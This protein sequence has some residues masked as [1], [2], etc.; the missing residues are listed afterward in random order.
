MVEDKRIFVNLVYEC[1][2]QH[3]RYGYIQQTNSESFSE[4]NYVSL[5]FILLKCWLQYFVYTGK[6]INFR[7]DGDFD[8]EFYLDQEVN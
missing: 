5:F 2:L 8:Y 4:H 7:V 3:C 1:W 6:L